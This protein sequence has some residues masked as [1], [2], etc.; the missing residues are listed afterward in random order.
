MRKAAEHPPPSGGSKLVRRKPE[1]SEE[2]AAEF[3]HGL[4]RPCGKFVSRNRV[5]GHFGPSYIF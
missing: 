2:Q 5:F 4:R 1:V 3:C